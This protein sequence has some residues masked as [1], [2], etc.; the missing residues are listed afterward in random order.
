MEF[1]FCAGI[2]ADAAMAILGSLGRLSGNHTGHHLQPHSASQLPP[3]C[4][5][6]GDLHAHLCLPRGRH[7]ILRQP[8]GTTQPY[9]RLC[10]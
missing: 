3:E 10:A 2:C 9:P 7:H 1:G 8:I 4:H 5:L 6:A